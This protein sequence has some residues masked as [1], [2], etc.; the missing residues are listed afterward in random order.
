MLRARYV[1]GVLLLGAGGLLGSAAPLAGQQAE[2]RARLKQP[3][4]LLEAGMFDDAIQQFR[5][6]ERG[7]ANP[8]TIAQLLYEDAAKNGIRREDWLYALRSVLTAKVFATSSDLR[9]QLHFWHGWIH[10]HQAMA[11][12]GDVGTRLTSQA[13][14]LF[15]AGRAYAEGKGL[16]GL[17]RSCALR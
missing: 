17:Y 5:V 15:E 14:A 1:L 13:C 8:D 11:L 6:A 16:E 3:L 4:E 10:Y 9:S 7:G 2:V 12:R